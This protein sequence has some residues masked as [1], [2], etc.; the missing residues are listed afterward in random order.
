LTQDKK[1]DTPPPSPPCQSSQCCHGCLGLSR[2]KRQKDES[3][4]ANCKTC[5]DD[6]NLW[7]CV[8][9]LLLHKRTPFLTNR[10]YPFPTF[11]LL[12]FFCPFLGLP[13]RFT[14]HALLLFLCHST[15]LEYF[16]Y[17]FLVNCAVCPFFPCLATPLNLKSK[18]L[19]FLLSSSV[20]ILFIPLLRSSHGCCH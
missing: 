20:F 19:S 6:E 5:V 11:V 2:H 8:R 16:F 1:R 14:A 12:F 3:K 17:I 7:T 10:Y 18:N 9:L 13:L 4:E 15:Q